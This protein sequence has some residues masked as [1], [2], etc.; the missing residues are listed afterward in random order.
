M[1]LKK[2][3]TNKWSIDT[4]KKSNNKV[5]LGDTEVVKTLK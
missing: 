1:S 3:P 2:S 5:T 4:N